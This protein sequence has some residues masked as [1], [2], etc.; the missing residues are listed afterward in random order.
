M[1]DADAIDP[2]LI[3]LV[4]QLCTRIGMIMEDASPQAIN[5]SRVGLEARGRSRQS[6][7][8]LG[9]AVPV[10]C[11]EALLFDDGIQALRCRRGTSDR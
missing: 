5:A 9:V 7:L 8:V 6:G 1:D 11:T 10:I 4:A 3:D 2:N